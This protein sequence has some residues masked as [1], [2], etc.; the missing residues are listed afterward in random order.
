VHHYMGVKGLVLYI[1]LYVLFIDY[2]FYSFLLLDPACYSAGHRCG[3]G[4]CRCHCK[5][6]RKQNS[7]HTTLNEEELFNTDKDSEEKVEN[8]QV[9]NSTEISTEHK[10]EAVYEDNYFVDDTEELSPENIENCEKHWIS[11]D[12]EV[13]DS[14]TLFKTRLQEYINPKGTVLSNIEKKAVMNIEARHVFVDIG[15]GYHPN[16]RFL[17]ENE[18]AFYNYDMYECTFDQNA[19]CL[20]WDIAASE[21][22]YIIESMSM[23]VFNKLNSEKKIWIRGAGGVPLTMSSGAKQA[24]SNFVS[25]PIESEEIENP[26]TNE[27]NQ[28]GADLDHNFAVELDVD[29]DS[30]GKEPSNDNERE[31]DLLYQ[32]LLDQKEIIQLTEEIQHLISQEKRTA[33]DLYLLYS[34]ND[35][36]NTCRSLYVGGVVRWVYPFHYPEHNMDARKAN[37]TRH[38]YIDG[39]TRLLLRRYEQKSVL[40]VNLT[41]V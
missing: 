35:E 31:E 28:Q 12:K 40:C 13:S 38:E 29:V 2:V 17:S 24:T 11:I 1:F 39:D 6:C 34:K 19:I 3:I 5:D 21:G 23:T 36:D 41:K 27:D 26:S 9:I 30:T 10:D 14:S 7:C 18:V 37:A 33:D 16:H 20:L 32:G 25:T 15:E 4:A 8:G 22:R